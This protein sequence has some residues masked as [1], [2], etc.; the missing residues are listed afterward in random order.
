MRKLLLLLITLTPILSFSQK[1]TNPTYTIT[2]KIIDATS[3]KPLEDATIIFKSIDSNHIKFGGITNQKGNFSIDVERE[4]YNVSVEFISFKTKNLNISEINRDLN[5]GIIEMVL[6]TEILGEVEIVSGKKTVEFKPNKIVFNVEKDIAANGG[7]ATDIL[8][9]IPSVSVDPNGEITVQGQSNVQVM[10]NGKISSLSK[11]DALKSLP[12]G[13]IEKIEVIANPGAKYEASALSVINIILK[14]GKDEG[15]NASLTATGGFKDYYGG[16]ITLNNKSKNLNFFV[17]TSFNHN[18]PITEASYENEYFVNNVTTSFLNE[19]REFSSKKDAFYGTIGTDFYLSKNTTLSTSVNFQNINNKSNTLTTSNIF[20]AAKVPTATNDRTHIGKLDN[21]LYEFVVDFE[22]NFKKEGQQLTSNVLFTRDLDDITNT[23]SNTNVAFTNE[24][25]TEKNKLQNTA[26]EINFTSPIGKTSAYSLGYKGSIGEIPFRYSSATNN[27]NIDYSEN[28]NA[29]YVEFENEGE[30]FYYGLGIRAEF[31]ELKADYLYLN[32]TQKNNFDK[33]FPTVYLNYTLSDSK[34]LSLSF[35][36][37]MFSPS[38]NQLQPFEQKYSETT[39]YIG[40]PALNPIYIDATN[41]GYLYNG[42]KM[43]VSTSLFFNRYNDYWENATYQTGEQ[44]NGV[45]KII[46][47]PVNVGKVDYYGIDLTTVY[48]PAKILNFTGNINLYNFDQ[49]GIYVIENLA[50][51]TIV[52]N[53]NHTS[54]NGSFSLL[55]QL[56]I[57]KVFDFQLNAKHFL[58]SKGAYSTRKEFTY[59]SAAIN[60]DFFD[61]NASI[62]LTVDDIF[63][64]NTTARDRFDTNYFSKSLIEDKYRTILLSFTYRFNQS[65]K[66]RRIDFDK[67]EIKPNY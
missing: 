21:E 3:K 66:D 57:P 52:K 36:K 17:N 27:R 30:K 34:S 67:K 40:N 12:A 11:T 16:L 49:S 14:K 39:S 22:H 37:K 65:K 6:D 47:T 7:V 24:A 56:K 25:Y 50:N 9:N 33:I 32:T 31:L 53:Y 4:T 45:N 1:N 29:V 13:S 55:T 43:M 64:T 60:K 26:F 8:N 51:E 5:L 10:I 46:T 41:L 18:N 38:Y 23:I 61:N 48:K 42:N 35:S 44:I 19:N 58:I 15:L 59:A 63:K 62:S 54:F 20:N 28:L 2:G